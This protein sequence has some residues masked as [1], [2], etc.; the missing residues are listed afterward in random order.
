MQRVRLNRKTPA[1]IVRHVF[2]EIQSWSRVWKRLRV[3][4]H[5]ARC[6]A[7]AKAI[8]VHQDDGA[9]VP[10]QDRTGAG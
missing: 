9:Y 3:Q 2:L 1:H 10:V 6:H 5:S 7:D 4:D 8:R